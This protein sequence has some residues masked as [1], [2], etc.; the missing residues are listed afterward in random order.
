MLNIKK[1]NGWIEVIFG[2]MFAG[3]SSEILKR[4]DILRISKQKYQ[5]FSPTIDDRYGEK[6]VSNHMGWSH[7]S[8]NVNNAQELLAKLKPE[9]NFIIIDEIQFFSKKIVEVIVKL[10]N[11]GK[12][13]IVAGLAA[14]FR[15]IPF[16][17]T[18]LLLVRAEYVTHLNSI[19]NKC[20]D[21]AHKIQRLTNGKASSANEKTITV[22]DWKN[23]HYESRC[24]SCYEM[25]D[26]DWNKDYNKKEEK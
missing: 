7:P 5:V 15:G 21:A 3:K 11:E 4:I 26:F 17:T 23:I 16:E 1:Q 13:I 25:K 2:C 12:K 22:G 19:C 10:A 20:Y 18:T 8:I 14:D 6:K 24:R 9:T